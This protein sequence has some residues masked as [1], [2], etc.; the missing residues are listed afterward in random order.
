[1]EYQAGRPIGPNCDRLISEGPQDPPHSISKR[2][3]RSRGP[4]TLLHLSDTSV[5]HSDLFLPVE[6]IYLAWLVFALIFAVTS[7]PYLLRHLILPF[8]QDSL[9]LRR[10]WPPDEESL[11]PFKIAKPLYHNGRTKIMD[12][13]HFDAWQPGAHIHPPM[14]IRRRIRVRRGDQQEVQREISVEA[15]P[16][17]MEDVPYSIARYL[18]QPP[19]PWEKFFAS[20]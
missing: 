13:D 18:D 6:T 8:I 3:A 17:G 10:S 1:M 16:L 11:L 14:E 15:Q 12:T 20:Q 19:H 9:L 4:G 5:V 2:M 7:L